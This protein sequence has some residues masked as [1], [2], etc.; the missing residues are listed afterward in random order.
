MR[1]FVGRGKDVERDF[2]S[3][4]ETKGD[5]G[6]RIGPERMSMVDVITVPTVVV[7]PP[8]VNFSGMSM[9]L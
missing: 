9:K 2:S 1:P 8:V 4:P 5:L 7:F 3:E 6:E